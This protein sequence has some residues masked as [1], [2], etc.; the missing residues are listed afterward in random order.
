MFSIFSR[1]NSGRVF[2]DHAST[3]PIDERVLLKMREVEGFFANPSAV[4]KEGADARRVLE[5]SREMIAE[6]LNCKTA[7]VIFTGS[8]TESCNLAIRGFVTEPV[9]SHIVTTAIEHPA[10]L[11]SCRSLESA[12]A[13]VTYVD[14][15]ENGV[16]SEQR[17]LDAIRPETRMVSV[18]YVNNEIG[19]IQPIRKI[20]AGIEKINRDRNL[21]IYF[22]S[23]ASQAPCYLSVRPEALKVDSMTL[24]GSKIYGPKGVGVLYSRLGFKLSPVIYGGGQEFGIRSGT[25]NNVVLRGMAEA[26]C[27]ADRI[28]DEESKRVEGL[29]DA[30]LNSIRSKNPSVTVNA[31]RGKRVPHIANICIPGIDSEFLVMR[32]DALGVACSSSS[33]CKAQQ[34][35]SVSHVLEAIGRG[36]CASSSL[37]FSL[38]RHTTKEDIFFASEALCKALDG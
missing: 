15:E 22:H 10:V 4:Y 23:D 1:K 6:V 24:D 20:G 30:L 21:P 28:R 16:V 7:E 5:E 26:L 18:M 3:T 17:V 25:E 37:R 2:L 31:D 11:E 35:G 9:G 8:G 38:G 36:E 14:A 32:L 19:T 34:K 33:S 12:G 27:L 29:R 13:S